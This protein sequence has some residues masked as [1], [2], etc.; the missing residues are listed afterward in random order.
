MAAPCLL[1]VPSVQKVLLQPVTARTMGGPL[2]WGQGCCSCFVFRRDMLGHDLNS[3]HCR[4]MSCLF[5]IA[6]TCLTLHQPLFPQP[7]VDQGARRWQRR[8][9]ARDRVSAPHDGVA[10]RTVGGKR[11]RPTYDEDGD[12][13]MAD[14]AGGDEA[15]YNGESELQRY[16]DDYASIMVWWLRWTMVTQLRH[17]FVSGRARYL[18]QDATCSVRKRS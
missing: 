17:S 5:S 9:G 10:H 8:Q 18:E 1:L 13:H 12:V 4:L 2:H 7:P 11:H 15:F 6:D 14:D 3:R 16:R